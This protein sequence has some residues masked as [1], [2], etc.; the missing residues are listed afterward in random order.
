MNPD[1]KNN[2]D[3]V[4]EAPKRLVEEL[5]AGYSKEIPV[6]EEL[7]R[8]IMAAAEQ[9]LA[10]QKQA[11]LHRK[12]MKVSAAAAAVLVCSVIFLF[13]QREDNV[14]ENS[15]QQAAT[16]KED[17]NGDGTVDIIDALV[18]AR[19]LERQ[20]HARRADHPSW[21]ITGDGTIT[22]DDVEKIA[23]RAVHI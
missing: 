12:W 17:I 6:P 19:E 8:T 20:P 1:D 22:S 7:D 5:K 14:S 23:E 4:Y 21:D 9:K 10:R 13:T 16:R 18:L 2:D 3:P 11:F 15:G